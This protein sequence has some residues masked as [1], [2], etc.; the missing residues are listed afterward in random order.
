[1][2]RSIIVITMGEPGGIG[3]DICLD[4]P[5]VADFTLVVLGDANLL[6]HRARLLNKPVQI[7]QII[8]EQL[9]EKQ[10]QQTN[11]AEILVVHTN[12]PI[13]DT[14]GVLHTEN[15]AYVLKLLDMAS[16]LCR[17]GTAVAM[18]TAPVNKE[19]INQAGYKFSG[20]TEYLADKFACGKVVMMLANRLMR[21]ALLTTHLPLKD[22]VAE[23]T[24]ANLEHT[25]KIIVTAF[26]QHYNIDNP[27][28]GVCGLNPHAGE[29]GYLGMEEI[30]IINPVIKKW[31]GLGYNI[32]G[33]YPADTIF[34]HVSDFDVVL[35][36][37]HDQG[38][39]VLKYADF[40]S[41]INITLGL[42]ILRVSVDHGTAL[43]LAGSGR[44]SSQSLKHA[45]SEAMLLTSME[46]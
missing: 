45:I 39:P 9:V 22:V 28:I 10:I 1:M 2:T 43:N 13:L 14:V 30:N 33:T 37:Y 4:L 19:V 18:V 31:Q 44:A 5:I 40:D 29:G 15:A 26:K 17:S 12:C 32:S 24:E 21:V 42:P 46:K 25:L 20:H 7:R 11:A 16:E 3:P 36:M 23:V 38:L 35:A 41:G 6:E 27:K 8:Y 34:N